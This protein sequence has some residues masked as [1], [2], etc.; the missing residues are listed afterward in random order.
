MLTEQQKWPEAL[1]SLDRTISLAP[2]FY[3]AK[4]TKAFC[5]QMAARFAE[6][7]DY[8]REI[9][10]LA[11]APIRDEII[12][13]W[14]CALLMMERPLDAL[15]LLETECSFPYRPGTLYNKAF[16]L[17]GLGRWPEAWHIFRQRHRVQRDEDKRLGALPGPVAETLAEIEGRRLFLFH[18][19]GLG[20]TIQFLRYAHLLREHCS[21]LTIGVPRP[22]ERLA[23]WLAMSGDY[24]VV[25]GQQTGH[26]IS[27]AVSGC[28]ITLPLM[29]APS[30]LNQTMH[31]IPGGAYFRIVPDDLIAK[32]SIWQL[33]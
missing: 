8:Y 26:G 14:A 30:V 29:D 11:D 23:S 16:I 22:L 18:E 4:T 6:S 31:N 10:Q 20:D 13:N 9:V 24:R 28:D 2:D 19:Q 3:H 27:F 32:R 15:E 21:E 5:L 25:T 7:I 17:L 33:R 1:A 12:N